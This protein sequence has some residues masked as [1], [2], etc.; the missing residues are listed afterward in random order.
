MSQYKVRVARKDSVENHAH[1][2]PDGSYTGPELPKPNATRMNPH[3]H[4]YQMQG[5][6][7]ESGVADEGPGHTHATALGESAGPVAVPKGK[8]QAIPAQ[9]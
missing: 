5:K 3:T 9:Q 6:T 7:M 1:K 4:L 8:G 2:L